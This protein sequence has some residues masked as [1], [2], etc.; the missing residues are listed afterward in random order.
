[1]PVWFMDSPALWAAGWSQAE[2]RVGLSVSHLKMYPTISATAVLPYC[3][4][5]PC[6]AQVLAAQNHPGA[7]WKQTVETHP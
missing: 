4:A 2:G 5:A 3:C 6:V 1:M 7:G